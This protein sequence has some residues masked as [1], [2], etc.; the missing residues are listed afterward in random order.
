[1]KAVMSMESSEIIGDEEVIILNQE[2]DTAL[3]GIQ[4]QQNSYDV[5]EDQVSEASSV[6][7]TLMEMQGQITKIDNVTPQELDVINIAVE[8]FCKRL[9]YK[10]ANTI[11]LESYVGSNGNR[12]VSLEGISSFI[13]SIWQAIKSA[14]LRL[15]E[16]IKGIWSAIFGTKDKVETKLQ[17]AEHSSEKVKVVIKSNTKSEEQIIANVQKAVVEI[18]QSST[19]PTTSQTQ[20]GTPPPQREKGIEEDARKEAFETAF[21]NARRIE[22]DEKWKNGTGYLD[23]A[24][25]GKHAPKVSQG[26]V[27]SFLDD[28]DRRGVI[29]GTKYG[30]IVV[31]ERYSPEGSETSG[32]FVCN[33]ADKVRTNVDFIKFERALSLDNLR[34]ILG[35]NGRDNIGKLIGSSRVL[36]IPATRELS[37]ETLKQASIF[38]NNEKLKKY[39]RSEFGDSCLTAKQISSRTYQYLA[40][41]YAETIQQTNEFFVS[42]LDRIEDYKKAVNEGTL[43]AKGLGSERLKAG[44]Y[45]SN[46]IGNPTYYEKNEE[47]NAV[48]GKNIVTYL[49]PFD[50]NLFFIPVHKDRETGLYNEKPLL[51]FRNF[52]ELKNLEKHNLE[53]ADFFVRDIVLKDARKISDF[54]KSGVNQRNSDKVQKEITALLGLI[55]KRLEK[56]KSELNTANEKRSSEINAITIG[57]QRLSSYVRIQSAHVCSLALMI[58]KY[59]L[60]LVNNLSEYVD[61]SAKIILKAINV[62][63]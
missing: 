13:D 1:M 28:K 63:P 14:F 20:T 53:I 51:E 40:G 17:A 43:N 41:S 36:D 30:N 62:K 61:G 60:E 45:Y 59:N 6:A 50:K 38:L 54:I 4:E 33:I 7:D 47:A 46:A 32:V 39:F 5:L 18:P 23:H 49:L 56:L 29:V 9:D 16:W 15:L 48:D 8:H 37:K 2:I 42:L 31:F 44:M 21:K 25:E 27:V 55:E 34:D 22:F 52:Q 10:P 24:A 19:S 3:L 12:L 57:L 35:H 58:E 26:Q 11:G